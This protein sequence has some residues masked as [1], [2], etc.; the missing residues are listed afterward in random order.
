MKSILKIIIFTSVL[1]TIF[2]PE[3]LL[4]KRCELNVEEEHQTSYALNLLER[5]CPEG[6]S[7]DY[8][9][10]KRDSS[11]FEYL[12]SISELSDEYK[13]VPLDFD[14]LLLGKYLLINLF[15]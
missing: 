11:L 9:N 8:R 14:F 3:T 2:L 6:Y 15:Y 10:R 1:V 5:K 12:I 4:Y 13:D 7:I